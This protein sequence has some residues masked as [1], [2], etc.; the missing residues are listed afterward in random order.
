[1]NNKNEKDLA[2][3][4]WYFNQAESDF[5]FCSNFVLM[6]QAQVFH[7][8]AVDTSA[9]AQIEAAKP[10]KPNLIKCAER[11]RRIHQIYR[12]LPAQTKQIL[13]TYYEPRQ[14]Q[15]RYTSSKQSNSV[16]QKTETIDSGLVNLFPLAISKVPESVKGKKLIPR[17]QV[18]A[19]KLIKQAL[20]DYT[21]AASKL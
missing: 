1:M 6:I 10:F 7:I 2:D 20:S 16:T 13:E 8:Q 15:T 17:L 12:S 14:H 18:E 21:T 3:L 9:E 4:A 11:H 5:G 19:N